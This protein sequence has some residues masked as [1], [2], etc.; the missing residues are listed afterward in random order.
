MIEMNPDWIMRDIELAD[1]VLRGDVVKRNVDRDAVA[2]LVDSIRES[3]LHTPI[4]VR[5]VHKYN[6]GVRSEQWELIAGRHRV[7]AAKILGWT[8]IPA[9]VTDIDDDRAELAMIDENLM[10]K[11]LE[12]ADLVYQTDRRKDVYERLH[13]ETANGGDRRST[14][15]QLLRTEN[16]PAERFTLATAKATGRS[17]RSVQ[18]AAR[19]G[20]K[21]KDKAPLLVGTTL[22]SITELDALAG[23][24][25][26]LREH[27]IE[28]ALRGEDVSAKQVAKEIQKA[29]PKKV[30]PPSEGPAAEKPAES[31]TP[32]KQ[33]YA[34]IDLTDGHATQ[35]MI[36]VGEAAADAS[37][38]QDYGDG[39]SGRQIGKEK[40]GPV[41]F[42]E[43]SPVPP[44][45]TVAP[46]WAA[47]EDQFRALCRAWGDAN[48]GARMRFLEWAGLSRH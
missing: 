33:E 31:L 36:A 22:N 4:R 37:F 3:G 12:P 10:R 21:L 30:K 26:K 23:L 19:I 41:A 16:E 11:D 18:M 8:R 32:P 5:L 38:F 13:P 17:E 1:I 6:S 48:G 14:S 43:E 45:E 9:N 47:E 27:V 28:R 29:K 2:D 44:D 35:E 42:E 39:S 7:E 24:D 40:N 34:T 15:S 25:E 20:K 46:P